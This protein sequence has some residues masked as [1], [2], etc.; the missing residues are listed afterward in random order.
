[1]AVETGTYTNVGSTEGTGCPGVLWMALV[2]S[3]AGPFPH[4]LL[5]SDVPIVRS[6]DDKAQIEGSSSL[7]KM[8]AC[9]LSE[10][11]L[12]RPAGDSAVCRRTFKLTDR[13]ER[14]WR[15]TALIRCSRVHCRDDIDD[16]E[17]KKS[18][19]RDHLCL[20]FDSVHRLW[21]QL[22][23]HRSCI[24]YYT[25]SGPVPELSHSGL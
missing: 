23:C 8:N 13:E 19:S 3:T 21:V 14:A 20:S 10:Y 16:D 11:P 17:C 1:M 12:D 4:L 22:G 5:I 25:S 2:I 18:M 7:Q 6:H 9:S 24:G 15:I